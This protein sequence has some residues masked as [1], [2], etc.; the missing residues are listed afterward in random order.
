MIIVRDQVPVTRGS[1]TDPIAPRAVHHDAV[2][3]R[4]RVPH[5]GR[6]GADEVAG[7]DI[8]AGRCEVDRVLE[9]L[10]GQ[11]LDRTPA[12]ADGQAVPAAGSNEPDQDHR[13]VT[14]RQ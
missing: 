6:A 1:P 9:S 11:S 8:I 2:T 7:D 5:A 3:V 4:P 10:E 13:V 12:R 14:Q